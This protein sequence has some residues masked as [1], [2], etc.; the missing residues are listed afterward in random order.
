MHVRAV[1]D[2]RSGVAE[3]VATRSVYWIV[4]ACLAGRVLS[5]VA[6]VGP[7]LLLGGDGSGLALRLALLV[8]LLDVVLLVG[9]ASGRLDWLLRSRWFLVVDVAVAIGINF[10]IT[11]RIAP[12][13]FWELGHDPLGA[14]LTATVALWT[15]IRGL[16]LGALLVGLGVLTLVGEALL[17][18]AAFDATGW[19]TLGYRLA[20]M[21][22][23]IAPGLSVVLLARHAARM[24]SARVMEEARA[25]AMSELHGTVLQALGEI[26]RLT[27]NGDPVRVLTEVRELAAGQLGAAERSAERSGLG[28]TDDLRVTV[29]DVCTEFDRSGLRVELEADAVIVP[30]DVAR[31]V[32]A[33]V[34]EALTNARK[35]AHVVQIV[36]RLVHSTSGTQI[37]VDDDGPGVRGGRGFGLQ[38]SIVDRIAA[39]GG[40]ATVRSGP[41]SGTRITMTLPDAPISTASILE[42]AVDW[43]LVVPVLLRVAIMIATMLGAPLA[44]PHH[45]GSYTIVT[46]IVVAAN[47]VL[48][49]LIAARRSG[50]LLNSRV[51]FAADLTVAVGLVLWTAAILPAGTAAQLTLVG[52]TVYFVPTIPLWCVLR[53]LRTGAA[54]LVLCFGL[55]WVAAAINEVPSGWSSAAQVLT[56]FIQLPAGFLLAVLVM[57][58]AR[59]G[60]DAALAAENRKIIG[61]MLTTSMQSLRNI[62]ELAGGPPTA[63]RMH[64]VRGLALGTAD[65]L[66]GTLFGTETGIG[67][68]LT[69]VA[70]RHRRRGLLVVLNVVEPPTS[71]GADVTEV[72]AEV[73]DDILEAIRSAGIPEVI[74]FCGG[75]EHGLVVTVRDH[76]RAYPTPG[77]LAW[78]AAMAEVGATLLIGRPRGGGTHVELRWAAR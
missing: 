47:A 24:A 26:T 10:W 73:V 34:R 66:D 77:E 15:V 53:G 7:I 5:T 33:A 37:C 6:V 68:R 4:L 72:V 8:A 22:M 46:G 29:A 63:D 16:R 45:A 23:M 59:N 38:N 19:L 70:R 9:V 60:V 13:S 30:A 21:L 32:A 43:F 39:V 11:S 69:T 41:G 40:S 31:T 42:R 71:V 61:D 65:D 54:L 20:W 76:G 48:L 57:R 44:L 75:E 28:G 25:H 52:T 49:A 1:P 17:N 2:T 12:G 64:K 35:H 3:R 56:H 27:A 62:L 18:G 67:A 14:Y 50:W 74:V 78:R 55:E 36:V 51:Y 58:L